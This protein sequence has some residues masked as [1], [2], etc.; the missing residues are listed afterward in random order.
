MKTHSTRWYKQESFWEDM[1]LFMFPEKRL[2]QVGEEI[3]QMCSLIDI[4]GG[5]VLDL[6]CGPATHTIPLAKKGFRVTAVD[7]TPFMLNKAKER[8]EKEKLD[9][10]LVLSDMRDFI[11]LDTFDLAVNLMTSVGYFEDNEENILVM[12][13]MYQNLKPGGV[14]VIDMMGKEVL[15]KIFHSTYSEELEDDSVFVSR[16][17][18]VDDWRKVNNKWTL[19]RDGQAVTY[20][21][22]H[23]IYGGQ[24]LKE[25]LSGVGFKQVRLFGKWDGQPY[26]TEATR[27][28]AIAYK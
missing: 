23:Y 3:D 24:E 15:A 5:H 9:V 8:V 1:Y 10:E 6:C 27:L 21:I 20:E 17:K 7:G 11:R 16:V 4:H 25:M 22:D 28:I 26:D 13:R 2:Q 12:K 19:I 18:I 14:A